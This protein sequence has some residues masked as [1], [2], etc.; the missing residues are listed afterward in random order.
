VVLKPD[1][2]KGSSEEI[3]TAPPEIIVDLQ[4]RRIDRSAGQRLWSMSGI[5]AIVLLWQVGAITGFLPQRYT[6]SPIDVVRAAV[7]LILNG[8]LIHDATITLVE[9]VI[10]MAAATAVGIPAGLAAGW[11]RRLQ[12]AIE[13]Y[14]AALYATPSLALLPLLVL[15][16]GIGVRSTTAVVL[17]S[18][19]FPIVMSVMQGVK[20]VD[21]G[22]IR[23]ARSFG[24]SQGRIFREIVLPATVPFLTSGLQLG[25]ARGLIGVVV[26]EM[27]AASSGGLGYMIAVSGSTLEVDQMFVAVTIVT[28]IGIFLLGAT[29]SLE[30]RFQ[31]WKPRANE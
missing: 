4:L 5:V 24:A 25:I 21:V 11:Y 26:G 6:S 3:S 30:Q 9:F 19:L 29:R 28:A 15:W 13:P 17:I 18:A 2:I 10:G 8:D 20:T 7:R 12:Y 23:M 31:R 16:F 1:V 27:Y 22:L 14:L